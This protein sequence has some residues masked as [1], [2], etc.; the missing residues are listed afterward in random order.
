MKEKI[1]VIVAAYNVESYVEK[2]IESLL[3]QTYTN[4]EI[5]IVEDGSKD[6]TWEVLQK[7]QKNKK[8]KLLKNPE[9]KGLSYSRNRGLENASGDYIG[10]IDSDDYVEENYYEAMLSKLKSEKS[11]IAVCDMKLYY[12]ESNTFQICLGCEGETTKLNFINN[13]LAASACNKLFKKEIISKY[14]FSEGKINED[15]AVVIPCLV[16][17]KNIS[18][19]EG[20]YYIY[21]QRNTSIQNSVFS[22]KRFD[23]IYGVDLTLERIKGCPD[24]K[25]IKDAIVFN[26]IIVLFIYTFP[27]IRGIRERAKY[28]KQYS[29]LT[30]KYEIRKNEFFW[31]FISR[32]NKKSKIY[33]KMLFKLECNGHAY[34]TSI[35]MSALKT[36]QSHFK[37]SVIQDVDENKLVKKA[38]QNQKRKERLKISVVIPNYNYE[39]Y[40]EQRLDSILSQ[41]EKISEIIILDDC[42]KDNSIEKIEELYRLLSP[43]IKIIKEYNTQ[44]SGSAFKQWEKGFELAKGDYVWIAEA[45]DYCEKNLLKKLSEPILKDDSIVISYSDTAFM[46]AEGK[47]LNPS[48]KPFID[49]METKHWDKDYINDGME[50]LKNY[51]FLNCTIANVSSALIKKGDYHD[52]FVMSR[53]YRQAGD[54]LFYVNMMTIGKIAYHSK[55]L[56]YYRIHGNNVSSLMKKEAHMKEIKRIHKYIDELITFDKKQKNEVEKRYRFLEEAW[57]LSKKN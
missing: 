13:G 46:D 54:W 27:K 5:I 14:K 55:S 43:H 49:L 34:L 56:N 26:Q 15:L 2:C 48:V 17:A 18:Y 35:L 30:E 22:S 51:S 6:K 28:L 23:I 19:I 41:T 53:E 8:I 21:V 24:Y 9:N 39:N 42:S 36:Y 11:D 7:Y 40:L 12:E 4:L 20:I 50:E 3:K 33:Y 37:N 32:A 47:I 45:D 29:E 25:D 10:Y 57:N 16:E 31:L 52:Y 38:I 44:N 1:S